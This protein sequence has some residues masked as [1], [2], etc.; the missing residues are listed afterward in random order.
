MALVPSYIKQL[1]SYKPGKP[2]EE[3]KRELGLQDIIKLASN[4]NPLGPS[5]KAKN[6]MRFLPGEVTSAIETSLARVYEVDSDELSTILFPE[7]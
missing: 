6:A 2:I 7:E 3:V 5:P 4:E 1:T